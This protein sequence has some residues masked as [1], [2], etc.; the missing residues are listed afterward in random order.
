[1]SRVIPFTRLRVTKDERIAHHHI[2]LDPRGGLVN[3]RECGA[4]LTPFWALSMLADQY[5]IA[6]A[7]IQRLNERLAGADSRILELS[8]EL[9]ATRDAERTGKDSPPRP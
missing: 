4:T 3:C 6:L 7:Q 9:D 1:M 5:A 8:T 2:R